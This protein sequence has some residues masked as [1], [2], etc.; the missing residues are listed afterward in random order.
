MT[1]LSLAKRIAK[2]V[3][4]G[5]IF[6]FGCGLLIVL[7]GPKNLSDTAQMILMGSPL[8]AMV[9]LAAFRFVANLPIRDETALADG[10]WIQMSTVLTLVFIGALFLTYAIAA[11]NTSI[12]ATTL[13]FIVG[14]IETVLGVYLGVIRDTWFPEPTV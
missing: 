9:G 12:S 6:V 7:A 13:K 11:F 4:Y 2:I 3:V 1:K 5:H 14:A 10:T 8:L